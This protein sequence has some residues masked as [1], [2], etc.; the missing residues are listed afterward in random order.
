L[1][2]FNPVCALYA[3]VSTDQQADKYSLPSQL[4]AMR[5]YAAERGYRI[6]EEFTFVDD[7][8]G[9]SLD[10]PAL[11]ALREAVRSRAVDIVLA[12]TLDRLGRDV[13]DVL[14]LK[15]EFAKHGVKLE[16][17]STTYDETPMGKLYFTMCAAF[18]ESERD[19]FQERSARGR[20]Q[21][22][23]DGYVNGRTFGYRYFGRGQGE[24]GRLEV[25]ETEAAICA[26][27]SRGDWRAAHYERSRAG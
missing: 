8:S 9:A 3:R 23:R 22:A 2:P 16:F 25:N 24:R 11:I 21:K 7:Y 27:F 10:R 6:S 14:S 17:V 5:K 15:K 18:A 26:S 19:L 1:K 13:N 20:K 12:Y 4:A